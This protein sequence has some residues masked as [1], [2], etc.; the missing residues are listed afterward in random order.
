MHRS[1]ARAEA[2]SRASLAHTEAVISPRAVGKKPRSLRP[3][4]IEA[5]E[6]YT[7]KVVPPKRWARMKAERCRDRT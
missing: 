4:K 7:P 6:N 5:I 3:E 1:S 2:P